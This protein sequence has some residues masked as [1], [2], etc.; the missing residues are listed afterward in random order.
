MT[1]VREEHSP[2]GDVFTACLYDEEN[3]YDNDEVY[4][5]WVSEQGPGDEW[6]ELDNKEIMEIF[7]MEWDGPPQFAADYWPCSIVAKLVKAHDDGADDEVS[8]V[9][10]IFQSKSHGQTAWNMNELPRIIVNYP[11]TSVRYFT[12]PYKSDQ[13]LPG[14]FRHPIAIRDDLFPEQWKNLKDEVVSEDDTPFAKL[15]RVKALD[16]STGEWH[17]C[18]ILNILN[19]G[20]YDVG[21]DDQFIQRNVP[22]KAIRPAKPSKFLHLVPFFA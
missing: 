14:A 22:H 4:E 1:D 8:Y 13:H 17:N 16:E 12:K 3:Y 7:G 9:V 6:K 20:K 18:R 11:P 21:C 19:D 15:D 2:E 10:R 5:E